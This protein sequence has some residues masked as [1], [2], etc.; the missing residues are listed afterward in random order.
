MVSIGQARILEFDMVKKVQI[1][2]VASVMGGTIKTT[3]EKTV[4]V[5]LNSDPVAVGEKVRFVEA[6]SLKYC[7]YKAG[8]TQ[9]AEGRHIGELFFKQV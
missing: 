7:T 3:C 9:W 4:V 1:A 2:E 8:N 5:N 6:R